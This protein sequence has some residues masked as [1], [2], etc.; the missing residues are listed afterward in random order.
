[1]EV[2]SFVGVMKYK[3]RDEVN[4]KLA[5]KQ[6]LVLIGRFI[7]AFLTYQDFTLLC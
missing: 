6:V 5:M 1:M 4:G 3:N 7:R 2:G